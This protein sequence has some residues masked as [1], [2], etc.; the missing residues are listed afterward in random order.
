MSVLTAR[1]NDE[2][3]STAYGAWLTGSR[4][5]AEDCVFVFSVGGGDRERNVSTILIEALDTAKAAGA[6][7][8]GVVGRD[9]GYTARVGDAVVVVPTVNP[10]NVTPHTEAFQAVIWHLLVTHPKLKRA[11]TKW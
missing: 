2:G 10:D 7:I 4:L 3:W 6:R 5:R 9:G 8:V 11:A 1:T